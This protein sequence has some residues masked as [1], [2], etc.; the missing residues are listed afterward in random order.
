MKGLNRKGLGY[1]VVRANSL[2]GAWIVE[3]TSESMIAASIADIHSTW[4]TRREAQIEA[5]RLNDEEK[6][7]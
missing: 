4:T 3:P 2:S 5:K 6:M 7:K 1:V